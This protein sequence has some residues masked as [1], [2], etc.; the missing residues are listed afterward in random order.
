[1]KNKEVLIQTNECSIIYGTL[2][3]KENQ[4][5]FRCPRSLDNMDLARYVDE[6]RSFLGFENDQATTDMRN[7]PGKK[8]IGYWRMYYRGGWAGRWMLEGSETPT[9][10]DCL[11]V[12]KMIDFIC[13]KFPKGCTWLMEDFLKDFQTWGQPDRYLLVPRYSSI[14]KVMFDTRYGNGD[15]PVRIYVYRDVQEGKGE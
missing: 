2:K 11:G 7:V 4:E 3:G 14:Y 10:V 15:Y 12:D 9:D 6:H 1:M 13:E 8:L 5:L